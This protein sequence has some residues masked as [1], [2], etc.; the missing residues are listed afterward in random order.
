MARFMSSVPE[1]RRR[2]ALLQ[3]TLAATVA[4]RAIE[5][6]RSAELVREEQADLA[7]S[8][9]EGNARV[10]GGFVNLLLQA[11]M[12]VAVLHAA[13]SVV[14]MLAIVPLLFTDDERGGDARLRRLLDFYFWPGALV[15]LAATVLTGGF[16]L[17]FFVAPLTIGMWGV[18]LPITAIVVPVAVAWMSRERHPPASGAGET[19]QQGGGASRSDADATSHPQGA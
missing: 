15:A 4:L 18:G 3:A 17:V 5:V 19:R 7:G 10:V 8:G 13:V 6:V 11:S 16:G 9:V 12:G 14:V 1:L 2:V